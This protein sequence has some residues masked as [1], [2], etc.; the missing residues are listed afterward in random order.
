MNRN[1]FPIY[2][3]AIQAYF[4]NDRATFS[5]LCVHKGLSPIEKT[6]LQIY[7]LLR[8]DN[9]SRALLTLQELTPDLDFFRAEKGM[10]LATCYFRRKLF[11]ESSTENIRAQRLYRNVQDRRGEFIVS[12][13]ASM[14]LSHLNLWDPSEAHLN[15]AAQLCQGE[16]ESRLILHGRARL[17]HLTH[18]RIR[19]S[20]SESGD[21]QQRRGS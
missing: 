11:K 3:A 4:A 6:L 13:N 1:D 20:L 12:Y 8:V 21:R 18:N 14:D 7:G 5:R 15:R 2:N 9:I 17:A 10:L 19:N 16:S